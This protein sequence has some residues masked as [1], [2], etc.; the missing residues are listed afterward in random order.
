MRVI[1][2]ISSAIAAIAGVLLILL[3]GVMI[4]EVVS[5]YAFNA[6]TLWASDMTYMLNGAL[7]M[8]ASA[9]GLKAN[10]H[11]RIDFLIDRLPKRLQGAIGAGLLFFLALPTFAALSYV[12]VERAHRS[13]VRG[14]VDPVSAFAPIIWP[15]HAAIAIGLCL[16]TAQ[17]LVTAIRFAM[18]AE[19]D[20]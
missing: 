6:P 20:E 15:F 18:P 9:Y 13:Y 11:V 7:F 14:E 4:F 16:L 5:R 3:I 12:A 17:T 2:A 10:G 19:P 1:D 8:M